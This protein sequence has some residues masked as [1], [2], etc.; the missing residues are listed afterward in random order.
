MF[1]YDLLTEQNGSVIRCPRLFEILGGDQAVEQLGLE[2]FFDLP[3][4]LSVAIENYD[5]FLAEQIEHQHREHGDDRS[6]K[7]QVPLGG[8][9]ADEIVDA[10][11]EGKHSGPLRYSGVD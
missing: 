8:V 7:D 2:P 3:I 9:P 1:F 4:L 6:G 11:R 5:M 10:Q